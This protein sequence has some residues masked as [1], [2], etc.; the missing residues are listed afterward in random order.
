MLALFLELM[1]HGGGCPVEVHVQIL[2]TL[3]ILV[4]CVKNDTSLYYLLSNNYINDI[5]IHPHDF[6]Q[7]EN[8]CDQYVSFMK[9]LSLRLDEKTVQFFFIEET[10]MCH[11]RCV[12][13]CVL[14]AVYRGLCVDIC[15]L[16]ARLTPTLLF[17]LPHRAHCR[18]PLIRS[19][20]TT[21]K[22]DFFAQL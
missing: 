1:S 14:C 9:S 21:R 13:C 20:P 12:V 10:G 19:F 11:L 7:H 6:L 17:T 22:S 16:L 15:L 18:L 2:Q 5:L 8:L 4:N 3:G